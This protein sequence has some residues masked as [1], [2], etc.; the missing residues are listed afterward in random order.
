MSIQAIFNTGVT[1]MLAQQLGMQVTGENISN[2]NTPGYSAQSPV[3]ESGLTID[4]NG[5]PMGTGV[6]TTAIRRT[7]DDYLQTL[8]KNENSNNGMYTTVNNY[9]QLV[10]PLFNDLS[11][12]G[13]GSSLDNFF[14]AFQNLSLNPAG[15]AERQAVLSQANLL[16]DNFHQISSSLTNTQS[17]ADDSL[18][19]ATTQVTSYLKTIAYLNSA[20]N[21]AESV[22]PTGSQANELRDQR[23]LAVRN[24]S[25]LANIDYK[26]QPD[27]TLTVTLKGGGPTLV[28]GAQYATMYTNSDAATGLNDI[29]VTATGN[30][31]P[32]TNPAIDTDITA[33][34]KADGTGTLGGTLQ[35]R[36]TIIQGFMDKLDELAGD[37]VSSVNT[38]QEA[39]Y[40]LNGQDPLA[41]P[42]TAHSQ[43]FFTSTGTKAATISVA[44]TDPNL[45]AAAT[46]DPTSTAGNA[47]G[48]G[49]NGNALLLAALANKTLGAPTSY[50]TTSIKGFYNSLVADVGVQGQNAQTGLATSNSMLTQLNTQ[51]ESESGVSLNE[52]LA[53][54]LNY[55]KSFAGSSKVIST[56]V[57]MYD[58]I[59]GLIR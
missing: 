3:F 6:Q 52:E 1:G 13:L 14:T 49:D 55:Q 51:R 8:L 36:D 27:K 4:I 12:S 38:V 46:S 2:V 28:S 20:I 24:L 23:E 39:G 54:M 18:T 43:D 42:P 19:A 7:Y 33:A 41:P 30:P 57:D 58:T 21:Q 25:Q 29:L 45:I 44:I 40:G 50:G 48:T 26:E 31:P 16:T 9:M 37:V 47:G 5:L 11:G 10:E 22:S 35:F 32:A 17:Q 56:A 15:T 34:L 53:N 59:L